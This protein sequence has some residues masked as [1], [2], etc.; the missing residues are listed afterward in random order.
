M[1]A[2][3][4]YRTTAYR[5]LAQ[6]ECVKTR[7]PSGRGQSDALVATTNEYQSYTFLVENQNVV[8]AVLCKMVGQ[9]HILASDCHDI[10]SRMG[11]AEHYA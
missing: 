10:L 6:H 9:I 8:T 7:G 11:T 5:P 3:T 4:R 1:V 2:D